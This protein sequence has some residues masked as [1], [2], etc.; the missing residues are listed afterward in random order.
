[1]PEGYQGNTLEEIEGLVRGAV[2]KGFDKPSQSK[3]KKNPDK[4]DL[5]NEIKATGI[6]LFHDRQNR[7]FIGTTLPNGAALNFLIRSHAASSWVRELFF[8]SREKVLTGQQIK[9]TL[10]T[11]EAFAQFR[12][13]TEDVRLRIGGGPASVIVDLGRADGAVVRIEP[14]HWSVSYRTGVR[15]WRSPG[16]GEL[17]DPQSGGDLDRLREILH[18]DENTWPLVLGFLINALKP[19][20]PYMCLLVEGEQG[21]GKTFLCS[22]IKRIIDPHEAE[23][24]RLA[25]SERDLMIQAKEQHL[26]VY[27]SISGMKGDIS[28]ALCVLATSGGFSTR[29]LY[30]DD[31]QQ[32]FKACNPFI[33]NGISE[34]VNRPDLLERAILLRLPPIPEGQ[35][36]TEAEINT[37]FEQILPSLLG[38]LYDAVARALRNEAQT[39]TPA[40][41]RMADAGRWITA[42]ESAIGLRPNTIVN[43]ISAAQDEAMIERVENNPV[44]FALESKLKREGPFE[45]TV[46]Q[47]FDAIVIQRATGFDRTLP[48]TPA[49]L[50]RQLKRLKPAAVK[51]GIYIEFGDRRHDGKIIRIWAKGQEYRKPSDWPPKF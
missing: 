31:E 23:K 44:I 4:L 18:L 48:A 10:E 43:A 33:I 38:C 30:T 50:S 5:V 16:F 40:N 25:S 51:A 15:L 29:R 32:I 26:L 17:P 6:Y 35:R 45:G 36:K 28:D 20:G 3:T 39:P 13:P 41:F 42:A 37:E 46:G 22:I 2:A 34:F 27:D 47:L 7:G 12:G 14:G 24:M 49:H 8:R 9:D 19:S 11:L 1:L 21:S